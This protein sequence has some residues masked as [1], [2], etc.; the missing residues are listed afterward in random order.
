MTEVAATGI[1]RRYGATTA[2]DGVDLAVRSGEIHA[3]VGRNGAGKS[4][5]VSILTGLQRADAGEVTFD[6][7]P[8]PP[9]VDRGAWR[10]RV[11][12]V[13][14]QSTVI[15]TL[16]V[17]ENLFL[18]RQRTRRGL[19]D[20]RGLRRQ[21]AELL[22]RYGV[23]IDPAVLARDLTVEQSQ[24]VEI[25]RALS[26]GA[27]LIILDEPTAR[28]DG[29][30]IGRLFERMRDLR[31]DGV[32]FLFIS[33]HLQEVY[34]ICQTV[35]VFR[36]ARHVLT[37][38]V[39]DLPHEALVRAMTGHDSRSAADASPAA[40]P[41]D[42]V[43]LTVDDLRLP[44]HFDHVDLRI[45][46][47]ELVGLTGSGS[48]GKV[49]LAETIAGLRRA[50]GGSVAVNATT[51]RSADVR[52]AVAAGLGY[53]PQDRHREG[54]VPLLSVAENA[55]MTVTDRLGPAA[56]VLPARQRAAA[57]RMIAEYDIRT[58]GPDQRVDGLSGGNAQKVVLAR[59][60][61]RDPKALVLVSPTAGV[62][63][64]SKESLLG[65]VVAAAAKG[66]GVLIVSDELDDLRACDRVLVMFHGRIVAEKP[67]GWTDADLVAAVE[68]LP[69]GPARTEERTP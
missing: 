68:G 10:Q 60:L 5:L 33:H 56:L 38:P 54:L 20:W 49:A 41:G 58:E 13:Y 67:R 50:Q 27:R 30:A 21:A 39:A 57:N 2:L 29:A 66:T 47:G 4:T 19:I 46:A 31:A 35:T 65:A 37:E 1:T 48:S 17:A 43:V 11:A 24:L 9:P 28:L 61:A 6:G 34:E 12:C 64:R 69:S 53:L 18:N 26:F 32:T 22:E 36:D 44:G 7:R 62:D 55:T 3:L 40:K 14:Q 8:A 52:A 42:E 15:P 59:A 23:G 45:R 16:T 51:I 63:V 25:A